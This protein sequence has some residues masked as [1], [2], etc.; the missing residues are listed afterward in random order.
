MVG[1]DEDFSKGAAWIRG[2]VVPIDRAS[3]GVLDWGLT[4]SDITY[5]V[6]PVWNGAFFR[7][8]DYLERFRASV[9][10][11]R[12][13][14]DQDDA[15]IAG[16]LAR[17]VATSGLRHAYVAMVASRGVPMIPGSRDPRDCANHFYAWC[18]PYVHVI[19]PAAAERG[20]SLWVPNDVHRIPEDSVNPRAKNY[21]W[22]DF[23]QGLLDAKVQGFDSTVLTDHAGNITEGPGFNIFAVTG[24][25]VVTPACGVLEGMTR[26]TVLELA[27]AE[28]LA[29]ETRALPLAEVLEVDEVFLS[30][31]SGGVV[32]VIRIGTRVFGNGAPGPVTSRLRTAYFAALDDP[33]LRTEIDYAPA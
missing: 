7:L 12:L 4:H 6:V 19:P 1:R 20:A 33:A 22:G 3:I 30:T 5:D 11:L 8:P 15:A 9:A 26:R 14:I 16:I 24:G 18:I 25:K 28:G 31:S 2:E 21:H 17:I 27:A 23:T 13:A 32:P 29:T 10:A